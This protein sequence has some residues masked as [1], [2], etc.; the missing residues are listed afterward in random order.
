MGVVFLAKRNDGEFEQQVALKVVRQSIADS[1][2]VDRFRRE[3]QIL[4]ALDHPNIA[5]LLDGGITEN[6]E[7]YLAMEYVKGSPI[8]AYVEEHGLTTKETLELFLKVCSAIVYAHQN[9]VVHRDIKPGNIL[10]T[11]NG[12]PKLLDLGLAKLMADD[13]VAMDAEQT[14]TEFRALTPAYASPEQLRGGPITTISDVYS[15]GV[16]LYECLTGKRPYAIAGQNVDEIL[17]LVTTQQITLP[18]RGSDR[19]DMR[20]DVD[21]IVLKALRADP[22]TRY[23]SVEKM[24]DDVRRHLAGLPITARPLTFSYRASKFLTRHR[25]GVAAAALILIA[26]VAGIGATLWQ[27]RRAK[28]EQSKAEARSAFLEQT[29]RYS[30]PILNPLKKGAAETTVNEVLDEAAR[31]LES[32]EYDN[33]PELKLELERTI[34]GIYFGQA[35]YI[36]ARRHMSEYV[37]LLRVLYGENDTR[38]L[39]GAGLWAGLL[40]MKGD[41][42]E[43]EAAYRQCVP[44]IRA[45]YERG[46]VSPGSMI[47]VLNSFAYLRRTQ[48]DSREAE[49]LFRE[50]LD[51][52]PKLSPPDRRGVATTRSTLASTIADQGRFD[53]ALATARS[54]VDD[55]SV[56]NEID[57][58]NYG[59]AMTVLGGFLTE[60]GE[61]AEGDKCLADAEDIYRRVLTPESLWLGDNLRNQALSFYWQ[62]RYNDA[63]RKAD[64][65]KGIYEAG[66][67]EKYD[68]FPTVLIVRG[69]S[70]VRLG[71]EREGEALLRRA[72]EMRHSTMPA[73]HYWIAAA[74]GAL[75]EALMLQKHYAE[76]VPLLQSSYDSLNASQEPDSPRLKLA[77]SRLAHLRELN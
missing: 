71:N 51:I 25:F 6:G 67:G 59:F 48:G 5:R 40:F 53:E 13:L 28:L 68:H 74:D 47:D 17:S 57:S 9:L 29:L 4:A 39:V 73:G 2:L 24:A 30:N 26:S 63:I 46:N 52:L 3:R 31:H 77:A 66:F 76:A 72:A 15:L 8:T 16:V 42:D 22:E 20:G 69:L 34:S 12:E 11:E 64:D 70:L 43:A 33:D 56:W 41:L 49:S 14:Q 50:S 23:R 38:S 18:S 75:G 54:A 32:G 55:F 45:E 27:A 1:Y 60:K 58:P 35:K 7:P 37:R 21:N 62:G 36:Q 44:A 61:Y 19:G 65:A 10:V